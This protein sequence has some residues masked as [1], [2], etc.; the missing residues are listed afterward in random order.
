MFYAERSA[1]FM[2]MQK[3]KILTFWFKK[4]EAPKEGRA[5][6]LQKRPLWW[7]GFLL[8]SPDLSSHLNTL[9]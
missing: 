2:E 9:S 1:E 6:D 4:K 8:G 3:Q 7:M 5:P